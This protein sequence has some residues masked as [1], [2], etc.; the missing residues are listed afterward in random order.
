MGASEIYGLQPKYLRHNLWEE[1][2]ALSPTTAEWTEHVR[3]LPCPSFAE[4][5]NP[6]VSETTADNPDLFQVHTP[7]KVDVFESLL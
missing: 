4:L 1:G 5:F 2:A 6:I 7:I 3:P